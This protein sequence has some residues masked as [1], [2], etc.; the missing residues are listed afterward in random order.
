LYCQKP[1]ELDA[2]LFDTNEEEKGKEK[3]DKYVDIGQED[4]SVF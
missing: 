4:M 3:E 2:P 1:P